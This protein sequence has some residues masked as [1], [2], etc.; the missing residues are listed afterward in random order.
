MEF[1]D[2]AFLLA[3]L[4]DE[5]KTIEIPQQLHVRELGD[6]RRLQLLVIYNVDVLFVGRGPS[7]LTGHAKDAGNPHE[8]STSAKCDS[9]S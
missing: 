2:L 9:A 7:G 5:N 6:L 1:N 3:P 8:P 4:S